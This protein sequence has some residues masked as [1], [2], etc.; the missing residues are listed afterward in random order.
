MPPKQW[1]PHEDIRV[2]VP[3]RTIPGRQSQCDDGDVR[4][5]AAA[6]TQ[7][8]WRK[9]SVKTLTGELISLDVEGSD[10]IEY[11]K[12]KIVKEKVEGVPEELQLHLAGK[13]LEDGY[14]LL[15]YNIQNEST[16]HLVDSSSSSGGAPQPSIEWHVSAC[17]KAEKA[18]RLATAAE[19]AAE[20][21]ELAAREA[22]KF[23]DEARQASVEAR[24]AALFSWAGGLDKQHA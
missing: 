1:G 9:I 5:S 3:R 15:D 11:V 6:G 13:V 24:Q 10:T 12:A 17:V 4:Q 16:L 14:T 2:D 22:V 7:E 19:A 21:A 8:I 20:R 18:D 23:A